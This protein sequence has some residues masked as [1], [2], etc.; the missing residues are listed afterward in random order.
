MI[1]SVGK[2]VAAIILLAALG[3]GC[4]DK[5]GNSGKDSGGPPVP[6]YDGK[7]SD[8]MLNKIEHKDNDPEKNNPLLN[9]PRK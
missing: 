5:S 7:G 1:G 8:P 3:S 9:P 4:S 6:K 2:V